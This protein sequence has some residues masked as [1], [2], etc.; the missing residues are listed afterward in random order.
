MSARLVPDEERWNKGWFGRPTASECRDPDTE[1]PWLALP[2]VLDRFM[3]DG[4]CGIPEL[5]LS[6]PRVC[7]AICVSVMTTYAPVQHG[8]ATVPLSVC[9]RSKCHC[10]ATWRQARKA[11][12]MR[13]M[14]S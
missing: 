13:L 4:G 7:A 10:L 6:P 2:I 5:K 8:F 11:F 9:E 14:I 12:L 3:A 1:R